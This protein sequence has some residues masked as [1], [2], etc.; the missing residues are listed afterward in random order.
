[1]FEFWFGEDFADFDDATIAGRQ[2][3]L[4]WGKS[5]STDTEIRQ[6]FEPLVRAAGA[7][8]LDEWKASPGGLAGD[9]PSARPVSAQ[10]LPR[11][12]GNVQIR[13]SSRALA[14]RAWNPA[15]TLACD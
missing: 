14:C 3:G 4:W 15:S 2:S 7:G 6:R 13:Q 1:M 5:A 11:Y 10:Y 12:A 8:K 9:H